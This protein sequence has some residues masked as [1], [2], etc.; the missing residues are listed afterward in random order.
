ME[1]KSRK[2]NQNELPSFNTKLPSFVEVDKNERKKQEKFLTKKVN[3]KLIVVV[4]LVF[5]I[6]ATAI[7]TL[8]FINF[9]ATEMLWKVSVT[10]GSDDVNNKSIK[11]SSFSDGMMRIS[12]DGITYIDGSGHVKWT[13]SYNMKDTI[14][15]YKDKYFAI[16]DRNG[17][18]FYIFD[19]NGETGSGTAI[20]PIQK[21]SLSNEG[22]LYLLQSDENSSYIN[23]YRNNGNL[24]DI[25]IKTNLTGDGMPQDI[26]TSLD[27]TELAV[28]Y[29]CFSSSDLYSKGTY[30]NFDEVGK[31]ANAKRIVGEFIDEFTDKYL[32]RAHFFDNSN[33]CLIYDGG[34][35][36]VS[37]VILTKPM[38]S[39][40]IEFNERIRS[41]SYNAD[42]IAIVFEDNTFKVYNKSGDLLADK[43]IDYNYDNFYVNDNYIIFIINNR[44]VI[45]DARGRMIFDKE[46]ERD[47]QYVAKKRSLLFTELLI[48]ITD[49]VE[50]IRFY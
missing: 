13:V 43:I 44:I 9:N 17:N 4:V 22:V 46:M 10:R 35:Y 3:L 39:K 48:G 18:S 37:T 32:A 23:L 1:K 47:V 25:S 8:R 26:C 28:A 11:Y 29:T 5:L 20:Y 7:F 38:I 16:A 41:I 40:H 34:V 2:Q 36:F 42:Y 31:N 49:G 45:Y 33:S 14:Y 24:V 19:V 27:G 12:N 15:D 50:C 6:I 30:Y 21:L